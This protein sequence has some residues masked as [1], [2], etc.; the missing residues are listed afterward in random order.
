MTSSDAPRKV[1]LVSCVGLKAESRQPARDLYRSDWF[2]K[3]R[4]YVESRAD[5]WFVLSALYGVVGSDQSID[6]YEKTLN[7]MSKRERVEWSHRVLTDLRN[8]LK[9]GD[10]VVI[11]AGERYR[12]FVEPELRRLGFSV[13]V[14]MAGLGIGEQLSWLKSDG[15][16]ESPSA[17]GPR[18]IPDTKSVIQHDLF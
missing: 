14:P 12:E 10:Q 3:A 9:P 1:Y 18:S 6:P 17:L 2:L 7:T 4:S 15:S 11:L 13:E 5:V 16:S 8:I